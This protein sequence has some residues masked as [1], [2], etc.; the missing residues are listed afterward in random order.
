MLF[1]PTDLN[2]ISFDVSLTIKS[3]YDNHAIAFDLTIRFVEEQKPF[4]I[5]ENTCHFII[6]KDDWEK[7]SSED[8]ANEVKLSKKIVANLFSI[9]IGT[10]RGILYAK[11]EHTPY[12]QF[13]LPLLNAAEMINEPVIIKK[14]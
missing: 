7:L 4:L 2:K 1:E 11:T 14:I 13:M 10:T 8:A 5:L 12:N 6:H 3:N 9:T